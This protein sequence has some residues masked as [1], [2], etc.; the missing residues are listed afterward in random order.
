MQFKCRPIKPSLVQVAFGGYGKGQR[1][2][3]EHIHGDGK[4]SFFILT[5]FLAGTR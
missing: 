5:F 2:S 4:E 3:R 1:R